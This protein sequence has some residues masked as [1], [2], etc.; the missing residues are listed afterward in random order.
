[1]EDKHLERT[2]PNTFGAIR[3]AFFYDFN[4]RFFEFDRVFRT[5][6]DAATAEVTGVGEDFDEQH[7]CSF[8][9]GDGTR[10][11]SIADL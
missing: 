10:R 1:M 9:T 2:H 11:W 4:M 5:N 3:A 8:H 7:Y 6:T